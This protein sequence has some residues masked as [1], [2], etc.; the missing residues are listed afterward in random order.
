[1]RKALATLAL[2]VAVMTGAAQT[3]ADTLSFEWRYRQV[4]NAY[5]QSPEAVDALFDMA[6]LY[7][8][9]SLPL[10]NLPLAM[11][12]AKRAEFN[13]LTLMQNNRNSEL[14]RL[15]RR[16]IL[17]ATVS[18]LKE[19]VRDAAYNRLTL[20]DDL[21]VAELDAYLD[22]FADD[23]QIVDLA[24]Q[25]RIKKVYEAEMKKGTI[26][27][28]Y[29]IIETFPHTEE[30]MQAEAKM[31]K[32]AAS[33]FEGI[34]EEDEIDSV[35]ALY[36][37]SPS[38]TRAAS[39]QKSRLAY[40]HAT[41]ANT[42]GAYK[43]FLRK[44]PSSDESQQARD[45]LDD[46]LVKQ[47]NRLR[48]AEEYARFA[49]S[50]A[51]DP[52]ADEALAQIRRIIVQ[53]RD[54]QA[55]RLYLSHYQL[56]PHYNEVF[57]TYYNWYAEEGNGELL[58][59]FEKE[60]PASPMAHA[61]ERDFELTSIIDN[62]DLMEP[63]S[64][65]E[66][67]TYSMHIRQSTGKRIA[68]VP[69]QRMLQ[70]LTAAGDYKTASDR[71]RQFEV[72]FDDVMHNEFTELQEILTAPASGITAAE[73]FA[74][75]GDV[76]NASL[77]A[78]DSLLYFTRSDNA[79]SHICYISIDR[80]YGGQVL[81]T[82][83]S[84]TSL[85][86][87][88]FFDGGDK[89]LLGNNG[90]IWIAERDGDRWRISDFLP[91][92]VNTDHIE[93]DAFMMPDGS[94]LLLASD[95]PGGQNL[96][97]SGSYYHGDTALATDL[98]FI[99]LRNG[100]WGSAI[101]LG[102]TLNTPYCERSPMMS[103]DLRTLYFITDSRGMGYGDI[104]TATRVNTED[105][106]AWSTPHNIGREVNT[107]FNEAFVN[108]TPDEQQLIVS[109]NASSHYTC[110]SFNLTKKAAPVHLNYTLDV[111]GMENELYRVRVA[112][113]SRQMVTQV[114]E[115]TGQG[116]TISLE[117]HKDKSYAI[118]GDAKGRFIPAIIVA[119]GRTPRQ[120]QCYSSYTLVSLDKAVPLD[121]IS[122]GHSSSVLTPVALLQIEQLAR[123]LNA[124][125]GAMAEI[126]IDVAGYDDAMAYSL[127]LERGQAI[128]QRLLDLGVD[129]GS[130][131][132]SAFGNVRTKQ[133]A[134][135]GVSVQFR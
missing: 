49:D 68:F 14:T 90:D 88:G 24:R 15:L 39:R 128:R 120:L 46:L 2:T 121:A 92:P 5:A 81:F 13:Y 94:G 66:F 100:L 60:Y 127:A 63:Y 132:I 26:T 35:A 12:F 8:D 113:I 116:S 119:P 18:Q 10:R 62:I 115:Y 57:I 73:Q 42:I 53:N 82:N 77:N 22:V 99:P 61:L 104:Y 72:C 76:L 20:H 107:C 56:D 9:N 30:A 71:M 67:H 129:A 50:N 33:L 117:L 40:T 114:V 86:L 41:Q 21:D 51:D 78:A 122:F 54:I 75:G 29:N 36:A 83:D 85:S 59:Q 130:I 106:T 1:M 96:Q 38:V 34:G 43:A 74:L 4:N 97:Q 48:T 87:F 95:R 64:E 102:I 105:W 111:L 84:N 126:D 89:M 108:L 28:Y 3:P 91:Y 98:Y 32:L 123:F 58:R 93:T 27:A 103:S 55:A 79:G 23:P 110:R 134:A 131:I 69:L 65:E 133:G 109:T 124:T 47:F 118:F 31:G 6:M 101:N 52:L 16:G 11:T 37:A 25:H 7:F 70:Q 112:D 17:L 125:S 44:Y 80:Q 19:S 135:E 45:R